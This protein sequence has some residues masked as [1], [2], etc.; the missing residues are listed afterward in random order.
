[1]TP[2]AGLAPVHPSLEDA[3]PRAR[4]RLSARSMTDPVRLREKSMHRFA[5]KPRA[6]ATGLPPRLPW[7]ISTSFV[8]YPSIHAD[9]T[10]KLAHSER[11]GL[12]WTFFAIHQV[13]R[14]ERRRPRGPGR[15]PDCLSR[16]GKIEKHRDSVD[17]LPLK[18][19]HLT[20]KHMQGSHANGVVPVEQRV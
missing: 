11:T 3:S 20:R 19:V 12:C 5:H 17:V 16:Q 7:T 4:D 13:Y 15:S 14:L 2:F 18:P 10:M 6:P 9:A 1:M 8:P